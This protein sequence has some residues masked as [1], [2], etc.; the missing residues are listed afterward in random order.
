MI[1][2][3]LRV[4]VSPLLVRH[5]GACGGLLLG[6]MLKED[7]SSDLFVTCHR[8]AVFR[9]FSA[10]VVLTTENDH[11]FPPRCRITA[12][13]PYQTKSSSKTNSPHLFIRGCRSLY[14]ILSV[15]N[16][17]GPLLLLRALCTSSYVTG[18]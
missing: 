11:K 13:S 1:S 18:P 10:F 3:P 12:K 7:Y 8:H 5:L 17:F 14:N 15:S 6:L 4:L 9:N 2:S 16:I